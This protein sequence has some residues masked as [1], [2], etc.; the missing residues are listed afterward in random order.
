[1]HDSIQNKQLRIS[2]ITNGWQQFDEFAHG[3][4]LTLRKRSPVATDT[5]SRYIA[6]SNVIRPENSS[7]VHRPRRARD[8]NPG[9]IDRKMHAS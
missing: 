7:G 8:A 4:A 1:V 6:S 9:S 2:T 5:A 3:T